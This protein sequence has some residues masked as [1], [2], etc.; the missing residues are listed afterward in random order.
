VDR[1]I[2]EISV[3]I[4]TRNGA[5]TLPLLLERLHG[6][7]CCQSM[8]IVVID[9]ASTDQTPERARQAGARLLTVSE[10]TF[11]HG[12]T[13][14]LAAQKARGKYLVFL[15]QDAI[16]ADS[17][18]I[19]NLIAPMKK[20][21]EVAV[22][23]GRQL[24]HANA[25]PFAR[26]L[27]RFNYG[28]QSCVRSLED[29]KRHGLRTIFVSNSCAAYRSS[30]LKEVG[31][32]GE[33]HLFAEDACTVGRLLLKGYSIAYV[34]EARVYHS[35]NYTIMEEFRRYF[36][37]GAFHRQQHW[38]IEEF[39]TAGGAGRSYVRSEAAFLIGEGKGHLLP[40]FILRTAMKLAGYKLGYYYTVLPGWL[41]ARLSMNPGW[42][43]K[44]DR[45]KRGENT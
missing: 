22:T 36:D 39:G 18:C 33:N 26:H 13:R 7:D 29:K 27:R 38:L 23:Y 5:R 8:E 12:G 19:S 24:P 37:V 44:N 21:R 1:A 32:F 15:T 25:T 20:Q 6:Q 17:S 31:Y 2:P 10:D 41:C 9:S 34:A 30:A 4:P 40:S 11:D 35:H 16:P 42:W 45:S 14:S 28:E 3:V 43:Q